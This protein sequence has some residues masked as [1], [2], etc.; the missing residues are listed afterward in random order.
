MVEI[1]STSEDLVLLCRAI[2]WVSFVQS[3]AALSLYSMYFLSGIRF[4][5]MDSWIAGSLVPRATG[6]H[7]DPNYLGIS[8]L[9]GFSMSL[10]LKNDFRRNKFF[11]FVPLTILSTLFVTWSRTV[12]VGGVVILAIFFINKLVKN[13]GVKRWALLGIVIISIF[14]SA[15]LPILV[16]SFSVARSLVESTERSISPRYATFV[17]AI[18][19]ISQN[20][21]FGVGTTAATEQYTHNTFL[22]AG[23]RSGLFGMIPLILIVFFP[24][25]HLLR[26]FRGSN[27]EWEYIRIGTFAGL[28]ATILGSMT[29]GIEGHKM[30]WIAVSLSYA[31][32]FIWKLSKM[33]GR[34]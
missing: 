5:I 4:G 10:A 3:I 26:S 31:I 32:V 8:L 16:D 21:L 2:V 22:Y 28:L 12:W 25:F 23:L 24:L 18:G 19:I 15:F 30:L 33:E 27:Q 17:E 13:C 9:M 29:M 20:P 1:P 6:A 34:N 11:L 7:L 14:S